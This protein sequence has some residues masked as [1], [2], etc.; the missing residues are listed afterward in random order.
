M[1]TASKI[2]RFEVIVIKPPI[3]FLVGRVYHQSGVKSI[4]SAKMRQRRA[5]VSSYEEH[6]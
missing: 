2:I 1:M 4:V 6:E 3:D 5:F